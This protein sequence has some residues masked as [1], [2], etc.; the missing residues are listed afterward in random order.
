MLEA[1]DRRD[2]GDRTAPFHAVSALESVIK[3]ISRQ[4]GWTRG[5]EKGAVNYI[6]NLVSKDNGRFIDV[7][8]ADMLTK[9]FGD[10][11]NPFGHGPGDA[12]LPKLSSE[13]VDWTIDT[14]MSWSKSLIQRM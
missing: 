6:S 1:L 8:E 4:K 11:R 12:D 7:W 14:A 13:Q 2:S 3:I 5:N 10:V 9:L